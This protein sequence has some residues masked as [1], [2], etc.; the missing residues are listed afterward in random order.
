MDSIF[1][2]DIFVGEGVTFF[3]CLGLFHL[4]HFIP[5]TTRVVSDTFENNSIK[6]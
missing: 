4:T 2:F 5:D 6:I 3:C 1:E